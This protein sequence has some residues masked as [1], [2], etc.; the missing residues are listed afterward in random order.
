RLFQTSSLVTTHV[1][2]SCGSPPLFG[3]KP[4]RLDY[5]RMRGINPANPARPAVGMAGIFELRPDKI[6][7]PGPGPGE[8]MNANPPL[9]GYTVSAAPGGTARSAGSRSR[10]PMP[11]SRH[12]ARD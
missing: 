3:T 1:H 10:L 12:T 9:R 11:L 4:T 2:M 5:I 8:Q 6:S 7:S